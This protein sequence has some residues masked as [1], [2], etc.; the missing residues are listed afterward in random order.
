MRKNEK[1]KKISH[2]DQAKLPKL[3]ITQFNGTTVDWVRSENMFITQVDKKQISDEVKLGYLLEMV[4]PQVRTRI[5]NLKPGNLGYKTAWEKLCR[6]CGQTQM[7]VNA[8]VSEIINFD[9]MDKIKKLFVDRRLYFNCG[10]HGHRENKCKSRGCIKCKARH[11]TSL[12]NKA[13]ATVTKEKDEESTPKVGKTYT[14]Y[15]SKG[16]SASLPAIVPVKI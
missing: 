9:T 11:H 7:V 14:G 15:T 10:R 1:Q 3:Q 5:A 13:N 12:C 4:C 2:Q 16:D 8:H 6:E